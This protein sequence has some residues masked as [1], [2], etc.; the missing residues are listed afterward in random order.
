M[1]PDVEMEEIFMNENNENVKGKHDVSALLHTNNVMEIKSEIDFS[2]SHGTENMVAIQSNETIY[3]PLPMMDRYET[4]M[5]IETETDSKVP[6][7]IGNVH[8]IKP[9]PGPMKGGLSVGRR[10]KI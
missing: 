6:H 9:E 7:T 1:E 4:S 2:K 10:L 3:S 5:Q 8:V